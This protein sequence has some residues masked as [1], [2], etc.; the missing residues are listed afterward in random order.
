MAGKMNTKPH[1]IHKLIHQVARV[2][3]VT[4]FFAVSLHRMDKFVLKISGGKFTVAQLAGWTI[5]QLTTV[6][7]KS[8]QKRTTPLIASMDGERIG[9]I[10]SS[11]G[12]KHNPGWYY[13]LKT[14][15][16]CSVELK[17]KTDIYVAREVE[18]DEYEKYWKLGVSVYE[19]YEK[20]KQRAAHRHI[21]VMVLEPKK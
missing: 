21:P 3:P 10:A 15:P 18:G 17:G 2:R 7:A 16:E 5:I 14:H 4:A 1:V 12:R 8:G 19:G 11:F 6:G 13:N 20:Y 9:L